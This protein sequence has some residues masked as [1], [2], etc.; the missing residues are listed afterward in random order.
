MMNNTF[1]L[2]QL[3]L[4]AFPPNA[5]RDGIRIRRNFLRIAFQD[6]GLLADPFPVNLANSIFE[7]LNRPE[8]VSFRYTIFDGGSGRELQ[9]QPLNNIAG[10]GIAT[11]ERPFK[12]FARPMIFLPRSTIRIGI[13]ERFGRGRL[14]LVFQ[15]YKFLGAVR[16]GG[17]P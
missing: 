10:L 14:F 1:P 13:E 3:P 15:G 8:D 5:L 12:K 4:L 6:N 7:S 2:T 11:G 16:A 9:N 17:L